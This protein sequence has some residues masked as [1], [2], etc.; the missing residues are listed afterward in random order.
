MGVVG[1]AF[2]ARGVAR[3]VSVVVVAVGV[4]VV[5]VVGGVASYRAGSCFVVS[6]F[7]GALLEW[8]GCSRCGGGLPQVCGEVVRVGN[9]RPQGR[10]ATK[11][12]PGRVGRVRLATS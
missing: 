3:V 1:V 8:V 9:P 5:V 2:A 11:R 7:A 6:T 10:W 12:C 4:A